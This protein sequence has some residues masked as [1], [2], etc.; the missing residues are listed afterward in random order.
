[1]SR[2]TVIVLVSIFLVFVLGVTFIVCSV[3]MIQLRNQKSSV[4]PII[5]YAVEEKPSNTSDIQITKY[6]NFTV[7][8]EDNTEVN[9][10]EYENNPVMIL[11]FNDKDS[12]SLEVLGE[13]DS[14][15]ETYKDTVKF[16]M[17]NTNREVNPELKDKY[18]LEIFY[19]FYK[20]AVRNYNITEFPAM[21]YI[22]EENTILNAKVGIP[23]VDSI[24]ANL[25]IISNNY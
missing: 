2:N 23:S 3:K 21:I 19:D 8:R 16:L 12:D 5:D 22:T 10:S 11:F 13:V 14:L 4:E 18:K 25:E 20:E 7:Y 17:V 24:D 15:Y 6:L 9:L 1:M